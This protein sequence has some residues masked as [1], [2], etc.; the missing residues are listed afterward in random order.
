M[1]HSREIFV[2]CTVS[3]VQNFIIFVCFS[4][5]YTRWCYL[6]YLLAT[7]WKVNGCYSRVLFSFHISESETPACRYL[8][9]I[10]THT[11]VYVINHFCSFSYA[12]GWGKELT[13]TIPTWRYFILRASWSTFGSPFRPFLSNTYFNSD[14]PT[15]TYYTQ[16]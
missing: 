15:A 5:C 8:I 12:N 16:V 13:T 10:I 2:Y 6:C 14:T 9:L 7:F 1:C 4:L 3:A 11:F